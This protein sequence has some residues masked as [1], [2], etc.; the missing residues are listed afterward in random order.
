MLR[1]P[2]SSQRLCQLILTR[3]DGPTSTWKPPI[4]G[5]IS[6]RAGCGGAALV[7]VE[8]VAVLA[9]EQ[10][11]HSEQ[12]AKQ[13][14]RCSTGLRG[15]RLYSS[16]RRRPIALNK[17]LLIL[18]NHVNHVKH[19]FRCMLFYRIY[20][21]RHDLHDV[22]TITVNLLNRP[23][24]QCRACDGFRAWRLL[25]FPRSNPTFFSAEPGSTLLFC[26]LAIIA[27][28]RQELSVGQINE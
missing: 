20:K 15:G 9:G 12:L 27:G 24:V 17:I 1:V 11:Q 23:F 19:T 18:L 2:P 4:Y 26:S 13:V 5:G 8:A 25:S 10:L 7:E 3:T 16:V 14:Y 21:I 28:S 22:P 6:I